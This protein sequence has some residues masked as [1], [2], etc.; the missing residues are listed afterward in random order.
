MKEHELVFATTFEEAE[1]TLIDDP[2][3]GWVRGR[4]L[5]PSSSFDA[6]I[7]DLFMPASTENRGHNFDPNRYNVEVPYGM[8]FAL[9]AIMKRVPYVAILT[10]RNHHNDPLM[11]ALDPLM[12]CPPGMTGLVSSFRISE[13]L[14]ANPDGSRD[15]VKDYAKTLNS[16]IV[17]DSDYLGMTGGL[18][19]KTWT[20]AD[21][22]RTDRR[23]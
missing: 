21:Q 10:D 8:V 22:I 9:T 23:K 17:V 19:Y 15:H 11:H 2:K 18:K 20:E 6:V 12:Q 4:K 16:L 14:T 3:T 7:T 1:K 13:Y 5:N